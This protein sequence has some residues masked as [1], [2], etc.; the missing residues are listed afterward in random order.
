M[1]FINKKK[2]YLNMYCFCAVRLVILTSFISV[3]GLT[4]ARTAHIHF[5]KYSA[6]ESLDLLNQCPFSYF[7]LLRSQLVV[8]LYLPREAFFS[9]SLLFLLKKTE[10]NIYTDI[11]NL[12]SC[13]IFMPAW[14]TSMIT[15]VAFSLEAEK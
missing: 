9:N 8:F 10:C 2:R 15:W 6:E 11:I 1:R 14:V 3:Y 5:I 12:T 4:G 7:S 13:S